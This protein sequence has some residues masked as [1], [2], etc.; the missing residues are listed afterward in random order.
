MR[1]ATDEMVHGMGVAV[2]TVA[3]VANTVGDGITD[4]ANTV[5]DGARDAANTVGNGARDVVN[6][7]GDGL[8]SIFSD[9]RMKQDLVLL[10]NNYFAPNVHLYL[11]RY[12][13]QYQD[14]VL[15]LY[16]FSISTDKTNT[17]KWPTFVGCIAQEV[18]AWNP[19]LVSQDRETGLLYV[20]SDFCGRK[21]DILTDL[22]VSHHMAK[23]FLTLLVRNISSSI[24]NNNNNN[25]GNIDH[26]QQQ[27][28][29]QLIESLVK[30]NY[31]SPSMFPN[32]RIK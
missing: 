28:Q 16:R 15:K 21:S 17:T 6:T 32:C 7:I 26:I 3:D 22:S 18:H 19:A 12:K 20:Q 31:I 24:T 29:H 23:Q 10:S 14:K 11:F 2:S 25:Y 13:P 9:I 1:Y 8:G 27:Q 5:G 4:V 30:L